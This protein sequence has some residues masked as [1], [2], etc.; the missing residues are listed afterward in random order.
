MTLS[1]WICMLGANGFVVALFGWCVWKIAT[2]RDDAD[3]TESDAGR[4]NA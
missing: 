3:E 2:I 4:E 1:G